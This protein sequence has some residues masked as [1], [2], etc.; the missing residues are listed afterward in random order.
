MGFLGVGGGG[1]GGK[2]PLKLG[3]KLEISYVSKRTYE[4]SENILSSK[5]LLIL[6]MSAFLCK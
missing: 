1:G 6:L 2:N 5:A 4:V 3:Y